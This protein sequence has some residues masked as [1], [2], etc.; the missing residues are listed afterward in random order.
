[1][2]TEKRSSI[3]S[4]MGAVIAAFVMA[5]TLRVPGVTGTV[6]LAGYE[7]L[8]NVVEHSEIDLDLGN[9]SSKSILGGECAS[10]CLVNDCSAT[11]V[12]ST[13]NGC[14]YDGSTVAFPKGSDCQ[15]GTDKVLDGGSTCGSTSSPYDI[16]LNGQ[17]SMKSSAVRSITG[18]STGAAT[19]SSGT[20]TDDVDYK[21]NA[22]VLVMNSYWLSK[23]LN[24]YTWGSDMIK[25]AFDGTVVSGGT[26]NTDLNFGTVGRDFRTESIKKGIVYLNIYPY[27]IWEMQDQV[28]DCKAQSLTSDNDASVHAWDEAVAFYAGSSV[29]TSYGTSS[30]GK[31]QYALADKRCKNFK[32]C[33]NG[34]TGTSY[35]NTEILALFNQGKEF[36]RANTECDKIN[37]LMEKIGTLSL[38]PFVQGTMRYL[39]KT[40]VVASAKEA[41]E[42]WAFAS[43]ILPF[44]HAVDPTVAAKLYNRAWKRDF[45]TDS[46]EDIKTGIEGTLTRLGV[47]SGVGFITC[48]KIG[49]LYDGSVLL[50]AGCS[51]E[52]SSSS[53]DDLGLPLGLGLGLPLAVILGLGIFLIIS[54]N[55]TQRKFDDLLARTSGYQQDSNV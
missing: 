54:R 13:G 3:L 17:N 2:L 26:G 47:G 21:D 32:T 6:Y 40:K 20:R 49:D 23:G 19:K 53:S 48:S 9:I 1:M 36:A 50:S 44:V 52:S 4:P 55:N 11:T 18:F 34:F 45:T 28:N 38:I 33:S 22:F 42:L 41:G 51:D 10:A 25:A 14:N 31:L 5:C 8:T 15:W 30:T 39:Y 37:L 16:Y 24:Q 35:V 29:G 7:P 12:F 43:A 27:V 46:Y